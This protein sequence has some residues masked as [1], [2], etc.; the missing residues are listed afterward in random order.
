MYCYLSHA[1]QADLISYMFAFSL[2]SYICW[3]GWNSNRE[4][5]FIQMYVPKWDF[6]DKV[7][8]E[9]RCDS[10]WGTDYI[11]YPFFMNLK[12]SRTTIENLRW[13]FVGDIILVTFRKFVTSLV[14]KLKKMWINWLVVSTLLQNFCEHNFFLSFWTND[15]MNF[16]KV[17]R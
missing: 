11:A 9:H 16:P 6:V 5:G 15:V 3:M 4:P 12:V 7:E 14:Q 1:F 2:V 17:M 10:M 13:Q 8:Q